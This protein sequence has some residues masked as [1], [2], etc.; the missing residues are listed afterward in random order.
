MLVENKGT[1]S[2]SQM[3]KLLL[4]SLFAGVSSCNAAYSAN[5]DI[6]IQLRWHHQFQFAGYYAALEKGFYQQEGL[7]VQIRQG[8][9]HHQPVS[10]VL[11][12]RAQY[13][14]GNSEV[15]YQR[16][17]GKPLV[18]LA[19]IFQH[20][21]S[22]LI[23]LEKTG[24]RSAHDLVGKTIMLANKNED[25]DFLTM[26]LNEGIA[27]SQVN[28]IPSSYQIQDLIEGKVDAFNSYT[29]NEPYLLR[30]LGIPY[31]IIDPISY[32]VDFYSDILFTS[33]Q[34]LNDHPLRVAAMRRATLKG[35][36]YA[37]DHP[38]EIIELLK[39]KYFV[40]KSW[41]HLRFE[42]EEMRKLI[43]PTLVE[44]GHMNP[45]RW[46]HMTN[47]FVKSGLVEDSRH[48]DGFLYDEKADPIP[49]W[50]MPTL[51]AALLLV[52]LIS[53]IT[54]YL[55]RFNRQMAAAQ[56]TLRESEARFKALSDAT[57]GGIIIHQ[58]GT[59]LECNNTLAEMTGFTYEELIGMNCFGFVVSDQDFDVALLHAQKDLPDSYEV[60][61]MRKDGNKIPISVKGEILITKEK[62]QG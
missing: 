57:Y 31:N 28:I 29:T 61:V 62:E 47:T 41:Q 49:A 15:L 19:A 13:A 50:V 25:A 60:T 1:L 10:E 16:L 32:R 6:V 59:I 48:F 8:D 46:L 45:E 40:Q 9:P 44:I 26:L 4:L 43:V 2:L 34:E 21:P 55:H 52:F 51:A 14:E 11:A 7:N 39:N 30:Q 22:V 12:G 20:S 33:E 3:V 37:M 23:S 38:E 58:N 27:L 35:W 24:I 36:R 42:A 53:S 17:L 54:F 56:D 18:A 5:N